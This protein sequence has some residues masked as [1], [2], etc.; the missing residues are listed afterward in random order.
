[1][2]SSSIR[3]FGH[4]GHG[5]KTAPCVPLLGGAATPSNTTS[6]RPRF[7]SV[8]SGILIHPAIW[9][10]H[11][12]AEN[13]GCAPLEEAAGS[14]FNTV[15]GTV[16]SAEAYRHGMFHLDPY[17]R[18]A[19]VGLHLSYRQDRTGQDRTGNG[20]IAYG[21]P[22]YKRSPNIIAMYDVCYW[23]FLKLLTQRVI[24]IV[25][26]LQN[27]TSQEPPK[28]S[29][30]AQ[31]CGFEIWPVS[32]DLGSALAHQIWPSSVTGG[33]YRRVPGTAVAQIPK[34]AQN[35]GLLATGSRHNEHIQMIFGV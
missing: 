12:C 8:P 14:P 4:N 34:I 7:T 19:T 32:V 30:F 15:W 10:Q 27:Y 17:S 20:L 3:P 35:C 23:T 29:K 25:L 11:I 33:R 26:L 1:V 24:A 18:L 21:E 13:W 6:P 22:F 9:P 2:E 28:T 16:A 31:N 5:P